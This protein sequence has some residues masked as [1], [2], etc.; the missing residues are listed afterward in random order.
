[1]ESNQDTE[2]R[3][4]DT[5]LRQWHVLRRMIDDDA[6]PYGDPLV[7]L[8]AEMYEDARVHLWEQLEAILAYVRQYVE[9]QDVDCAIERCDILDPDAGTLGKWNA[10]YLCLNCASWL[11]YGH[12]CLGGGYC[13]KHCFETRPSRK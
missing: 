13:S 3:D 12:F 11:C 8:A 9:E 1:M 4:L 7:R 5:L 2:I 10:S 6:E